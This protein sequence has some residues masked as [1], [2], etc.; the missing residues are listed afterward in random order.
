[1]LRD[2]VPLGGVGN[3]DR[4]NAMIELV[5]GRP[6]RIDC[7]AIP[8]PANHGIGWYIHRREQRAEERALVFAITIV[9][10]ERLVCVARGVTT[11]GGQVG[12]DGDVS[13]FLY[14]AGDG[15]NL[16]FRGGRSGDEL[17][18]LRLNCG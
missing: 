9:G 4:D 11:S 2:R 17:P 15:L 18:A 6:F 12:L 3:L 14:E 5:G 16:C 10:A 1:M 13:N 8:C 7:L